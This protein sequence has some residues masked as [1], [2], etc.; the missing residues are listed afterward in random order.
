MN[1]LPGLAEIRRVL[2]S[3]DFRALNRDKLKLVNL[4]LKKQVTTDQRFGL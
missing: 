2:S 1:F 3:S 4:K